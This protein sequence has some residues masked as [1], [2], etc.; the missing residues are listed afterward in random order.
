VASPRSPGTLR[1]RLILTDRAALPGR[2]GDAARIQNDLQLFLTGNGIP[3]ALKSVIPHRLA[4]P[5]MG[6]Y[7]N[8]S[9]R[10]LRCAPAHLR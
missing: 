8:S 1:P 3:I 4:A 6:L 5:H 7:P 10:T 2:I 9:V